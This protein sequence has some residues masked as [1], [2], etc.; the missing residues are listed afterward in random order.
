MVEARRSDHSAP[1]DELPDEIYIGFVDGLLIDIVPVVLLSAVA[2][3]CGEIAAAVAAKNLILGVTAPAQLLIAAVRLQFA[4]RHAR[5]I[6]SST[7]AIARIREQIFSTGAVV[8]LTALS[9]WTLLA[10]CVTDNNFAHFIGVSMTIAYAFSLMSRSYAIYRGINLQ[11]FGAFAP[12][13]IAMIVAGGWYPVGI[14][15][16]IAPLVLYMKSYAKRLRDNFMAVVASQQQAAMLAARLD[17]A[18]NNMSH[19]LCMLTQ[20]AASF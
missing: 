1:T 20:M 14:A 19:G 7:V 10:F 11:L 8:S 12:L 6:P 15:V 3:T 16:G 9:S 5:N 2:V 13:S 17:M 18:L 4:K